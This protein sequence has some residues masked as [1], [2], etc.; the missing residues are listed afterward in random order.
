MTQTIEMV[1]TVKAYPSIS[2]RYGETVCVAGVR[3]DTPAPMWVRLYP[4]VYRD[5]QFDLRFAKYQRITLDVTDASDPRPESLKPILDS[6]TLG[7]TVSTNDGWCERRLLVEPLMM[8][9]MCELRV[10]QEKERRSLGV[11]R[12]AR[13]DDLTIE[14]VNDEW[15]AG[16]QGVVDQASLFFPGKTGLEKIPYRFR[17][18]YHCDDAEC[19]GHEQTVVDWEIAQLY[20]TL[21]DRGEAEADVLRKIKDKWLGQMCSPARDTAFF[22]GNQ[23]RNPDG[24]LVLGVFWPPRG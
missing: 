21:R 24:F 5:L 23:F 9:S 2:T 1:V 20:R 15:D 13:V 7:D 19:P 12:P 8:R 16:R 3:T 6:L 17:Y 4:V 22:V 14:S 18:L 11:F 10:L